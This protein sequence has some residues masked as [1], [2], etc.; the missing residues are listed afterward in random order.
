MP[1][2]F[3]KMLGLLERQIPLFHQVLWDITRRPLN[4]S[5]LEQN[6]NWR[7]NYQ[8]GD[9]MMGPVSQGITPDLNINGAES[10]MVNRPKAEYSNEDS[11]DICGTRKS[12]GG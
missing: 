4:S 11:K 6:T 1:V 7:I 3:P 9:G 2:C 8:P 12:E 10:G 5:R